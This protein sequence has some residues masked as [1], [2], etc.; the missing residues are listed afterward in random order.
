MAQVGLLLIL[1]HYYNITITILQLQLF[2]SLSDYFQAV[3]QVE[4]AYY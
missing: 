3:A 2:K 1:L 4:E